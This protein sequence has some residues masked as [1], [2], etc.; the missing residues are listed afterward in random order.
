[1]QKRG[2]LLDSEICL[3][4]LKI[5]IPTKKTSENQL[6]LPKDIVR[7]FPDSDYFDVTVQEK[8]IIL[9]PVKITHAE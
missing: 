2:F 8:K 3:K 7:E 4:L 9:M 1:M 6:T 5:L